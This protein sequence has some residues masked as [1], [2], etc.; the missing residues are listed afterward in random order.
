VPS[1][2]LNLCAGQIV[3]VFRDIDGSSYEA[4]RAGALIAAPRWQFSTGI[5]DLLQMELSVFCRPGV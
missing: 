5:S 2:T 4:M 3:E 1:A